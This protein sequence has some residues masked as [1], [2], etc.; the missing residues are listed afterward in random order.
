MISRGP[1]HLL[2]FCD[3][4]IVIVASC[5]SRVFQKRENM[6]ALN[7]LSVD[8][9]AVL[10]TGLTTAAENACRVCRGRG[11][12]FPCRLSLCKVGVLAR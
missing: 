11:I 8:G 1:F 4:V 9:K 12:T 7:W 6:V 5:S 2:R 10:R 3:C